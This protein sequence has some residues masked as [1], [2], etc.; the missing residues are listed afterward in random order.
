MNKKLIYT[1][2]CLLMTTIHA[3]G[4]TVTIPAPSNGTLTATSATYD[5]GAQV[6]LTVTPDNGY[7]MDAIIIEQLT[8][9]DH[10]ET[11][12]PI[13]GSKTTLAKNN[14]YAS[15]HYGGTYSFVM[16]ANDVVITINF[17]ACT[18]ISTD[19][20]ITF[21]LNDYTYSRTS[22]NLIVKR[23]G[24][25]MA[26][27]YDYN[28]ITWT[29]PTTDNHVVN[30]GNYTATIKGIG[31]YNGQ[32][33]SGALTINPK[34]LT[35]SAQAKSKYYRDA[36]PALT[37][38]QSGLVS[39]D[40]IDGSLLRVAGEDVGTYTIGQGSV[41]A[42]NNYTI[43][44]NSA[45]LTINPR[46]VSTS[47]VITLDHLSFNYSSGNVQKAAVSQVQDEDYT[48]P[49]SDYDVGYGG[50]SAYGNNDFIKPDIYDVVVTFKNNY[51]G[52]K[53]VQ[54]Q[55]LKEMNPV[56]GWST[57]YE[58]D[59]NMQVPTGFKAYT[60]SG[61]SSSNITL[62]EQ[63]YVKKNVPMILY[64][65]SGSGSFYPSLVSPTGAGS[66]SS[67]SNYKR[68]TVDTDVSTLPSSGNSIWI[69]VDGSFVRTKTGTLAAGKCYLELSNSQ[70]SAARLVMGSASTGIDSPIQE[71]ANESYWYTLDG[72][73]LQGRPVRKG[74][75]IVNGKKVV[76]K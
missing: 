75:Y 53:T 22:K 21:E 10:A 41:S 45:L 64:R 23:D 3:N 14:N 27:N 60:I 15:A 1:L 5:K 11:R 71:T 34:P 73:R 49:S 8:D 56:L 46:N 38:T 19:N 18:D 25:A 70:V 43:T 39:G 12:N 13:I 68:V 35:I 44:Y 54:Y 24:T 65:E 59:V 50:T 9:L 33:T 63:S 7:Y 74:I 67:I 58:T 55:I 28:N 29:Y 32:K 48:I 20:T 47:A 26:I 69:L 57:Y 37:Y 30:V 31:I 40:A 76:I 2:A 4:Y 61:Y 17:I 6:V 51:T 62:T 52:S 66:W 16:P 72:R 36:D 42:G